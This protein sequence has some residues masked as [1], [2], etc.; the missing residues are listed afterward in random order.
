MNIPA[1]TLPREVM[2]RR[3]RIARENGRLTQAD[4]AERI[5]V[6]R[7]T[8]VAV[9]QGARAVK[10]GEL[11]ALVDLYG[12]TMNHLLRRDAVHVDLVPRFR[13]LAALEDPGVDEAAQLLND[14]VSAEVELESVL[15]IER[16]LNLPPE[17]SLLTGDVQRQAENDA[18]ELRSW[19]GIGVRPITDIRALLELELGV[20]IYE[21]PLKG[22][23][24]GLFAFDDMVGACM[25]VNA[26]HPVERQA[27]TFSHEVGHLVSTRRKPE[28]YQDRHI[29]NSREERYATVFGRVFLMPARAVMHKFKEIT[30]GAKSLSRRHVIILAHYFGVS[31]EAAVR[32]LE[33]L[34]LAPNGAWDW[35]TQNGGITNEQVV[36][37]LGFDRTRP[38][39]D[40]GVS[41]RVSLRLGTL[42]AE[43]MKRGLM[44]EGQVSQLLK[45]DRIDV[46]SLE[47]HA[48]DSDDEL[49]QLS[50]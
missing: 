41:H 49:C 13:K 10:S 30:A 47:H 40:A 50:E 46:R 9:E 8:L 37:V 3:L 48:E 36:E 32:R 24:S 42:A 5:G 44:S 26:Q 19:L 39:V 6:S 15:G 18:L 16:A 17:R 21:Y 11:R 4:A 27:Q 12:V 25:L 45:I 20:R 1:N 22:N 33:E 2:G 34:D 35:F 28:V 29:Q 7:T 14:L 23:V 43:A 38:A 31:R